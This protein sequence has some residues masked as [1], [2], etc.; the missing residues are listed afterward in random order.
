M[1]RITNRITVYEAV[2]KVTDELPHMFFRD[3]EKEWVED[4]LEKFYAD[5]LE[6]CYWENEHYIVRTKA[7]PS[8]VTFVRANSPANALRAWLRKNAED[9]AKNKKRMQEERAK[10]EENKEE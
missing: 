3:F 10:R 8:Q 4:G 2:A 7:Y 5:E 1:G 6:W 9:M